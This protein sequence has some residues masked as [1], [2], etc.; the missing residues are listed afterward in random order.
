VKKQYREARKLIGLAP[1]EFNIDFF[2]PVRKT[3]GYMGG[4]FGLRKRE[5]DDRIDELLHLMEL[6]EH[7]DKQFREVE[8]LCGR[9][10]IINK[11]KIVAEGDKAEF[12]AGGKSLEAQYLAITQGEGW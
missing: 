6:E 4:Y 10:A 3:L 1:Q 11:G 7:A 12:I 5:R 2:A 9:I 8:K